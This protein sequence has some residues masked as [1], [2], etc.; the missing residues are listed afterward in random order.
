MTSRDET[1]EAPSPDA[2][3]GGGK[4]GLVVALAAGLVAAGIGGGAGMMGYLGP[5]YGLFGGGHAAAPAEAH[6]PEHGN[7]AGA[8]SSIA[9]VP[10]PDLFVP[11][12]G[13]L[14][15]RRLRVGVSLQT[16]PN[17]AAEVRA[18]MPRIVDAFTTFLHALDETDLAAPRG[19]FDLKAQMLY[20]ARF[21]MNNETVQEVLV[22]TFISE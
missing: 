2:G 12:R 15:E 18:A 11:M 7:E 19:L 10:V 1:S 17:G 5:L 9:Y 21:V 14:G 20:R 16:A 4:R 22:R 3:E 6:G 8:A 13:S